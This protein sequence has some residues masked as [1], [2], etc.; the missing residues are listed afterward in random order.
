MTT[1]ATDTSAIAFSITKCQGEP[2]PLY[3]H[4]LNREVMAGLY[5][6]PHPIYGEGG[7]LRVGVSDET[8]ATLMNGLE[9]EEPKFPKKPTP[10]FFFFGGVPSEATQT[11]QQELSIYLQYCRIVR[12]L[13]T[14]LIAAIE[15]EY[16]A[17]IPVPPDKAHL[18]IQAL[19][20]L[21]ILNYLQDTYGTLSD[22]NLERNRNRLREVAD[23]KQPIAKMF[24]QVRDICNTALLAGPEHVIAEASKV[25]LVKESL[26][27]TGAYEHLITTW[28]DKPEAERSGKGVWD[29]F[30]AHCKMQEELRLQ[31]ATARTEG[32][33]NKA[34]VASPPKR[35]NDSHVNSDGNKRTKRRQH[36]GGA[37]T[38]DNHSNSI[39]GR[40]LAYCWSHG[41]S[42]DLRHTSKTCKNPRP[43][44][45]V[46][47]TASTDAGGSTKLNLR[48]PK[49]T[50]ETNTQE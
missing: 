6:I 4:Q 16:M 40:Q 22:D 50:T 18:G 1:L 39:N 37:P 11:Y 13:R 21:D 27:N 28:N 36:D 46:D 29:R 8:Y 38:T 23:P 31:S 42:Y 2:T 48:L 25:S 5:V 7:W 47:A 15:E 43:G 41:Y 14:A 30:V 20:P 45:Q 32:Y 35:S 3:V 49:S 44:H 34:T 12:A 10:R 26:R 19:P 9:W 17:D 33:A 24:L